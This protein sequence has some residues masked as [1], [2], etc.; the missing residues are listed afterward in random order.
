M[1]SSIGAISI[2]HSPVPSASRNSSTPMSSTY[3]PTSSGSLFNHG[4]VSPNHSGASSPALAKIKQEDLS[5]SS[6][7]SEMQNYM[8][9]TNLN[10]HPYPLGT[11]EHHQQQ[12]LLQQQQQQQQQLQNQTQNQ[13]SLSSSF[14]SSMLSSSAPTGQSSSPSPTV[15]QSPNLQQS[16]STT[17]PLTIPMS[18]HL[19]HANANANALYMHSPSGPSFSNI[20]PS[21][22]TSNI[23]SS[24]LDKSKL[25]KSVATSNVSSLLQQ[26]QLQHHQLQKNQFSSAHLQQTPGLSMSLPTF[27]GASANWHSQPVGSL[28]STLASSFNIPSNVPYCTS[29]SAASF[30]DAD[31]SDQSEI[32]KV[33]QRK[34]RESHNA[35]ERRR[36]DHI[37]ERIYELYTLIPEFFMEKEPGNSFNSTTGD[38]NNNQFS[39]PNA[40]NTPNVTTTVS[41]NA[42]QKPIKGTILKKA[43][44]YVK[45]LKACL[46]EHMDRVEELERNV[47]SY[48]LPDEESTERGQKLKENGNSLLT[49]PRTTKL[50][51]F[52]AFSSSS[53]SISNT[54][55]TP[56]VDNNYNLNR[57]SSIASVLSNPALLASSPLSITS[58]QKFT[59]DQNEA[60]RSSSLCSLT[61]PIADF[62]E[63][64]SLDNNNNNNNNKFST[65]NA[66]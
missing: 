37:N 57:P 54:A 20:S 2:A 23:T 16:H 61:S 46:K 49:M 47:H 13:T 58:D 14:Q 41:S 53:L 27:Q 35:I 56:M 62:S 6:Y 29:P 65:T 24:S 12:L 22:S 32:Q 11:Y 8:S 3:I 45:Q 15:W 38:S 17:P 9:Q 66:W 28:E 30:I 50:S 31:Q 34:R 52:S 5:S 4:M 42:Q 26:Q 64:M 18:N 44:E 48:T 59:N 36:R 33:K 40:T 55:I 63:L 10:Y 39:T 21:P 7:P 25:I 51:Q 1:S 19:V 43:V 60:N